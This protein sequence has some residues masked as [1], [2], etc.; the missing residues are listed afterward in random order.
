[1]KDITAPSR[2]TIE[3][4]IVERIELYKRVPPTGAD[5]IGGSDNLP[6]K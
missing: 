2:V 4:M 1:M 3:Q 6:G 5:H